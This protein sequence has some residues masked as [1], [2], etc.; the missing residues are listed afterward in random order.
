MKEPRPA[1]LKKDLTAVKNKV[2][3]AEDVFGVCSNT[4]DD[5]QMKRRPTEQSLEEAWK[6][7]VAK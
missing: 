6:K 4:T 3:T 5:A 1:K 7:R 2:D